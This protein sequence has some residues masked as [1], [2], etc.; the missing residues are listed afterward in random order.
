MTD[1]HQGDEEA[2]IPSL[3]SPITFNHK[4]TIMAKQKNW[5]ISINNVGSKVYYGTLHNRTVEEATRY[6]EEKNSHFGHTV[7][8]KEVEVTLWQE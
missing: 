2:L 8:Y 4:G 7:F 3:L 1:P 5:I 6:I